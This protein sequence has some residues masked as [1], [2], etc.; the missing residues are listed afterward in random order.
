MGSTY[1]IFDPK[2]EIFL[3]NWFFLSLLWYFGIA[4]SIYF[5]L[6][7]TR[8]GPM[9]SGI[10][11]WAT[12]V[13]WSTDAVYAIL[14][15]P[16]LA[17]G[18]TTN[19]IVFVSIFLA[20]SLQLVLLICWRW[21]LVRWWMVWLIC[22]WWYWAAADGA[23]I[24]AEAIIRGTMAAVAANAAII[25]EA[26]VMAPMVTIGRRLLCCQYCYSHRQD[27]P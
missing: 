3:A 10:I 18:R 11:G 9:T 27:Q 21:L 24:I 7:S 23:A 20:G 12:L 8:L 6:K 1:Y 2:P 5:I 13:F 16:F 4:F 22:W 19:S 14:R 17:T 15:H 26:I 25:A